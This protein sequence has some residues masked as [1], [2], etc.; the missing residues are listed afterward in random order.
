MTSR[1]I[2]KSVLTFHNP[3]RIGM[4]LPQ[5]YL[6]DI[7]WYS[8]KK[9][10][11]GTELPPQE[12]E[13]KRWRDAWGSV[14][15]SLTD[16]DKG[17]VV[18]G[19]ITDWS[20]LDSYQAPDLGRSEDYAQAAIQIATEKEKYRLGGIP[21]FTFNVAR[22]IRKLENYLCDLLT[23]RDNILRLHG[24][25]RN[26]LLRAIDCWA[27]AGADAI[28]FPE[29]WGTQDRLM[30]SPDL[31]REVFKPEFADLCGRAH[32]RGMDVWMHSCGRMTD[33][34]EDLIEC[35]VN[36]LQFDQPRLHGIDNLA[37][38]FAGRVTFWCPVDIQKTLQTRDPA[39]IEQEAAELV[40]KLGGRGGGFIAGYYSGNE[41]IGLTNDI[42]DIA[43]K[44]FVKNGTYRNGNS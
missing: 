10:N 34:I 40:E 44:A 37:Q 5:P 39:L 30:V 22:Y 38:R 11:E 29:D 14:W 41:A 15:A 27:D 19:A 1:Q 35:G 21:G 24:I 7:A 13:K 23:D 3:P 32:Q 6:N 31:W 9:A 18:E 8:R 26:Q 33:I 28:M 25:V 43:C 2:I 17:E 12:G 20:Q 36:C 16:Y 42:Q 4:A